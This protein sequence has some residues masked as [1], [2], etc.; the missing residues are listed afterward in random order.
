MSASFHHRPDCRLCGSREVELVL[1][2]KPSPPVDAYV[3]ASEKDA[4]QE[5]FPL[6]AYLCRAC[7]HVQLLDVVK[8]ELL[9]GR[10]IYETTSSPGLVDHFRRYAKDV[11]ETAKLPAGALAVDVGSN[12]GT[13]LRLFKESGLTVLGVDP[14]REI[15]EKATRSGVETIASFFNLDVA[16]RLR[17]ERGPAA[18][19]TANNVFAHA[20][21]LGGMADGVRELLADDG[22]FVFEVSY[23]LDIIDRMVF[24]FI[25]HEHLSHHSVRPLQTFLRAHGLELIDIRRNDSKGGTLRGFAQRIGGPR[26]TSAS[27]ENLVALEMK[28]GLYEPAL[29]R[30]YAAKI[31]AVKVRLH[32]LLRP[33]QGRVVAG[34]GASATTTVLIH[35][36][37]LGKILNFIID[38]NPRRQGL[39]SPG[40]HIPVLPSSALVERRAECVVV[41]AWRFADMILAQNRAFSEAGGQF[42]VPLPEVR[43]IGA[44]SK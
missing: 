34:Y 38:D 28:R 10:Y 2:L 37:E 24:D 17:R 44:R 14:A 32:E 20:D 27:V 4:P 42:I 18:L 22:L 23:L 31:D 36:F 19:V 25:Y 11:L 8:P 33:F 7:G 6:D 29:Y 12:D 3:P 41:L 26:P 9:F 15:A 30:E 16:K 1:H 40:D 39:F 43:V 13:L 5:S 35:H 21:D